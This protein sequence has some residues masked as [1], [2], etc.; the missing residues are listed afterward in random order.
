MINNSSTR[1]RT[2]MTYPHHTGLLIGLLLCRSCDSSHS[3]W[4]F[5]STIS[6]VV[7]KRRYFTDQDSLT[8]SSH[9]LSAPC[10]LAILT[11]YTKGKNTQRQ[12]TASALTLLFQCQLINTNHSPGNTANASLITKTR[13]CHS[14]LDYRKGLNNNSLQRQK[15]VHIQG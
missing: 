3:C 10:S 13:H 6:S 11:E 7:S 8:S 2:H 4:E 15:M 1:K 14:I 12:Y 5:I 9:S